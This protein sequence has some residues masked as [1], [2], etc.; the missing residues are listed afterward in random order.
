MRIK[1]GLAA[2][3][4]LVATMLLATTAAAQ[5]PLTGEQVFASRCKTC[6]EPPIERAPG[7]AE[8]ATR[9]RADIVASLV[10][11]VMKPMASGLSA[12]DIQAVAAYLAPAKTA[13]AAG[14]RARPA[15]TAPAGTDVM[16]KGPAPTLSA[17]PGDWPDVGLER[18][19]RRQAAPGFTRAEVPRLTVAWSFAM[20]GGGQPTAVGD[21][22]FINNRS[23]KFYALDARTGCVRWVREGVASRTTPPVVRTPYAPSG[24]MILAGQS[25]SKT[26][27][28]FDAQTGADIWKSEPL[29]ALPVAGITGSPVVSGDRVF[30]PLTSGE[31]G[32]A[33]QKT[34]ACCVFRGSLAALDLKTGARLWQT[35][36]IDEP[37]RVIGKNEAGVEMRGPAGAA[38]WGAPTADPKRGLVYVVTG[39]SYTSLDAKRADAVVALDMATGKIRWSTQV[40][41]GDNY[42][43]ACE[44]QFQGP[45]CPHNRGPDYDFGASP[46]L[47]PLKGGR[48]V[49][50]AGQKSGQVH[51]LD[52]ATGKRLWTRPLGV[53]S[54]LGGVEWGMAADDRALYVPV[55]DTVPAIEEARKALG[56]KPLDDSPKR[57]GKAGLYAVDPATGRLLWSA[58]APRAAC[59][60]AGPRFADYSGGGCVRAQSAPAS[61]AAGLVFSGTLDGWLRAYD[62]RTGAIVWAYSTTAQPYD[63]VNG[64]KG[65][66]G[67]GI[68]GMGGGPVIANGRV[69]VMSG[70]NGASQTGGNGVNV[71]LAFSVDGL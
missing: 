54:Q 37:L 47:F 24:W 67:G 48:A 35:S 39:D 25:G 45:N 31:E 36:M 2:G 21:W 64:V 3:A 42:V 11:G 13:Q 30:V 19:T 38:I 56:L 22:V 16:C 26:V 7:R 33:I 49:V 46:I 23:G 29:D 12:D 8:L 60:Y 57:D 59:K 68:D 18:G 14:G 65:Q 63:T 17:A 27:R 40:T 52:A 32:A 43:M 61:V 51:G 53:G 62:A 6:H 69:F 5:T 44:K 58:P 71:L 10:T 66:P 4:A 28:A 34:Y 41:V 70:Y 15:S 55:A 50:L 1:A 20:P 9:A